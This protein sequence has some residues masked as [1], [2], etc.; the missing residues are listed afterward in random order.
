MVTYLIH[1]D[2]CNQLEHNAI[3]MMKNFDHI[4]SLI[5]P[6]SACFRT[7]PASQT[8]FPDATYSLL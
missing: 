8:P 4:V 5:Y 7:L 6:H 2:I 3:F 1:Y